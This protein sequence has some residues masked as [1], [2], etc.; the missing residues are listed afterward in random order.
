MTLEI[1]VCDFVL[2]LVEVGIACHCQVLED[3]LGRKLILVKQV[4]TASKALQRLGEET[5]DFLLCQLMG[6]V[7]IIVKDALT[8]PV[9]VLVVL[10]IGI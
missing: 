9:P 1:H 8:R 7:M 10:H 2:L 6:S 5:L 4:Q 3:F